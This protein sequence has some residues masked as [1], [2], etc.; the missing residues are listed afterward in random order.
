MDPS[1][2]DLFLQIV[3]DESKDQQLRLES[4]R[5]L[6][7]LSALDVETHLPTLLHL[8]D[9]KTEKYYLINSL[10]YLVINSTE[11]DEKSLLSLSQLLF[12]IKFSNESTQI[13]IAEC[14]GLIVNKY[15]V[16]SL[17]NILSNLQSEDQNVRF[18]AS[19]SFRY[20][21]NVPHSE[22]ETLSKYIEGLLGLLND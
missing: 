15:L 1:N 11:K 3:L 10:K 18:L 8:I 2:F 20:F 6:G 13:A 17:N 4:C 5:A 22:T 16:S 12:K 21:T 14:I 7:T 19:S 9:I